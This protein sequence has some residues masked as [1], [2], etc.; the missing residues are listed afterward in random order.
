MK[1]SM[2]H[3]VLRVAAVVYALVLLFESGMISQSTAALSMDTHQYLANAV[4]MSVSVEP[5]ELNM[6]TA[7]LTNQK[8]LL[9][10]RET[11]LREREIEVGLQAGGSNERAT[12]VLA[13]ILFIL[14]V[15]IILNYVLDFMRTRE[16]RVTLDTKTV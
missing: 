12:Y 3:R 8:R 4:G 14:L 15:L 6:M 2:Y 9:D 13:S 11:T 7:E 1:D 5:T 10:Q 16:A